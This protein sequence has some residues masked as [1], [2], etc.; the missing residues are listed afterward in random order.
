MKETLDGPF[1]AA[2][3]FLNSTKIQQA[4]AEVTAMVS[5]VGNAQ[6]AIGTHSI[7]AMQYADLGK[8]SMNTN[9]ASEYYHVNGLIPQPLLSLLL[10]NEDFIS[11]NTYAK[12]AIW[13]LDDAGYGIYYPDSLLSD[14]GVRH[15]AAD[16]LPQHDHPSF[17]TLTIKVNIRARQ[18]MFATHASRPCAIGIEYEDPSNAK[19]ELEVLLQAQTQYFTCC[20]AIRT[21]RLLMLSSIG[22]AA[23]LR[24]H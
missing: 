2:H 12:C 17:A 11:S 20:G 7:A 16:L 18:I 8:G 24:R 22:R 3:P 19:A 14:K 9:L 15:S 5:H 10:I 23:D 4:Y 1:F 13:L 6:T 21:P